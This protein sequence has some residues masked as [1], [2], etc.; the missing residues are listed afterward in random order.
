M[1]RALESQNY[2]TLELALRALCFL[3]C[4]D[5]ME[6]QQ[7]GTRVEPQHGDPMDPGKAFAFGLPV[8]PFW[9]L[10]SLELRH[11]RKDA[12]GMANLSHWLLRTEGGCAAWTHP[13]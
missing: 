1:R 8:I 4:G 9:F 13:A 7:E 12:A 2:R 11:T 3:R 6:L 5:G 10:L